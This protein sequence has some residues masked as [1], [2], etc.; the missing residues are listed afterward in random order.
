MQWL[1]IENK[2]S[3]QWLKIENN[4]HGS[5]KR[6]TVLADAICLMGDGLSL[7]ADSF[8]VQLQLTCM[9]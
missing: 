5:G 6:M 1:K 7:L 2:M 9:E 4:K 3:M 8:A